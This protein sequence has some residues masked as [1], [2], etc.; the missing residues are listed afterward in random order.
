MRTVAA[1]VQRPP[2][3]TINCPEVRTIPKIYYRP[4]V[5]LIVVHQSD[6]CPIDDSSVRPEI[7]TEN[8]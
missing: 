2:A 3:A 7:M 8:G 1:R 5:I 6:R 4:R